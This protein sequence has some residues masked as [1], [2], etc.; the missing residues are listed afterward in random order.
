MRKVIFSFV[1]FIAIQPR[2][3][4]QITWGGLT[5]GASLEATRN[6]LLLQGV[7][8]EKRDPSW[9][10]RQGWDFT[11]VGSMVVLHFTPKLYFS[12][13]DRLERVVL[14]LNDGDGDLARIASTSIRE[15]LIGKYGAPATETPGCAGVELAQT[16][17]K[18]GQIDCKAIWRAQQQV[19]TLNWTYGAPNSRRF[20]FEIDYVALQNGF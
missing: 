8:L 7:D 15:Q 10:I 19:V 16:P 9:N 13:S 4:A 11:P 6:Y 14:N 20:F 1:W 17:A 12:Q 18:P 3:F 2:V 5:F